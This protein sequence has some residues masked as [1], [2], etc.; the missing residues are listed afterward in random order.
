MLGLEESV[1]YDE[2]RAELRATRARM[3]RDAV[4]LGVLQRAS[5]MLGTGSSASE[6][7]GILSRSASS[8]PGARRSSKSRPVSSEP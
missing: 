5:L 4:R 7:Q 3:T 1:L 6:V 2:V 8:A